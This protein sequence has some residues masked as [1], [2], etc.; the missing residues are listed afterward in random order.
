[1][2]RL[3]PSHCKASHV[4]SAPFGPPS[5]RQNPL[6]Y[7]QDLVTTKSAA[8]LRALEK[9]KEYNETQLGYLT[10]QCSKPLS[11]GYALADSPV[12]LLGW[13][14][15][16]LYTWSDNY[17]WTDEELITWISIYWFSTAGPEAN[18][19]IYYEFAHDP[20]PD[21]ETV[22]TG[23]VSTVK[24]AVAHFPGEIIRCPKLWSHQMGNVIHQS[25]GDTGGHFPGWENPQFLANDLK[26]IF[27]KGGVAYGAVRGRTGY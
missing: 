15:E 26:T 23:R 22:R 20:D 14:V 1:M 12:A 11:L 3:Y 19:R 5:F 21:V 24:Y 16:K 18:V 8:D 6:L 7:L 4:T 27:R 13:I 25:D 9:A 10:L 17:P 2:G